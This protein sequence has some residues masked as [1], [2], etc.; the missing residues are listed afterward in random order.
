MKVQIFTIYWVGQQVCLSLSIIPFGKTQTKPF[1]NPILYINILPHYQHHS[2]EWYIFLLTK[3]ETI[4]IHNNHPKFKIYPRVHFWC[5]ILYGFGQM[6]NDIYP[7]LFHTKFIFSALKI[8]CA[9][10]IHLSLQLPDLS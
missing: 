7:L 5:C 1:A 10:L 8:I 2:P 6:H 9:L 3:D 4:L